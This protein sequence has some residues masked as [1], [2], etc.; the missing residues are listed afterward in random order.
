MHH[1]LLLLLLVSP[2]AHGQA[3]AITLYC[4]GG[5]TGGGGGL[6]VDMAGT[7]HRLRQPRA[8]APREVTPLAGPQAPLGAWQALLDAAR[9]ESLARGVPSNMTCS[10]SRGAQVVLWGGPRSLDSLPPEIGAV[11]DAMRAH[12]A[13]GATR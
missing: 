7:L 13:Q 3:P 12:A 2:V 6:M 1:F 5:V 4:G 8:G 10:L 11:V 9:F